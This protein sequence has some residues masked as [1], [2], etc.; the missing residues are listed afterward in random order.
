MR[1][2]LLAVLLISACRCD[3]SPPP[4]R[5]AEERRAP[6]GEELL[7]KIPGPEGT[8]FE[9]ASL[10]TLLPATLGDA[11]AEGEAQAETTALANE[12]R[13]P[14][15]R[16]VYV[17]DSTR[18]TVQ[19]TDMQHA[20]LMRQM[21]LEAKQQA[22][23]SAKPSWTPAS[24][25]GRDAVLQHL[26]SNSAAIANVAVTDRLFLNVRVEP[27]DD[28]AAALPWAEKLPLEPI[29]KLA[30]PQSPPPGAPSP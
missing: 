18:I 25:Q 6:Q 21:M 10:A 3:D 16:R 4:V 19:L 1:L 29:T 12:G 8:P 24:V 26:P 15:A 20:P 23:K 11:A 17:K 7:S 30:P 14:V 5:K 28:A 2:F 13:L 9:A 22:E 27:A